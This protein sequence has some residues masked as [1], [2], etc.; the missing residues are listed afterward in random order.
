MASLDDQTEVG[1]ESPS[2]AGTCGL[3]IRVRRGHVVGELSWTLEHLALI[4]RAVGVLDLL[5]HGLAL[6]GRVGD[7]DEIAPGDAVEGMARGADLAVD[8]VSTANARTE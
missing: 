5:S 6:V 3:F 4:V 8:L 1:R 7:A 2:V